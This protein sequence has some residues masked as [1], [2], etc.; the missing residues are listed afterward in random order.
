MDVITEMRRERGRLR[1]S[2]NGDTEILVPLALIRERPLREGQEID[3]AEYRQWLMVR[4]YRYGLDRAVDY[5]AAR[6]HSSGEIS[7]KLLRAGYLPETVEMVIYKL[8]RERLLDD[9]AFAEQ[10]AQARSA[11]RYGTR[12]I[13]Q[14]LRR[15][16]LTP[17]ETENALSAVA[18]DE[19]TEAAQALA[20]K[21]LA[22]A[23]AGED[24][25]KTAQRILAMLA[26][27]GYGYD[28]A[29]AA[30]SAVMQELEGEFP[31]E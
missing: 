5:L 1:V 22:R 24:P 28:T 27:R 7:Q 30:L 18:Q 20:R 10:W 2:I 31:E 11:S 4:Q 15:K 6:P 3:L 16:G 17:Q 21:A 13:A 19:Q 9:Q 29:K 25:R 12:R 26:R 23:K 8:K 14:E